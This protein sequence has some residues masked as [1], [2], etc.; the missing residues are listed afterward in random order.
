MCVLCYTPVSAFGEI[1]VIG[2]PFVAAA[3]IRIRERLGLGSPSD[4][5]Q[6]DPDRSHASDTLA[7]H[8]PAP[9]T[10]KASGRAASGASG[11]SSTPT[12]TPTAGMSIAHLRAQIVAKAPAT[13][14]MP[15]S[16]L[17]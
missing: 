14:A 10:M 4:E 3:V 8:A 13:A 7:T 9:A 6:S 17:A 1:T 16:H 11:P 15:A 5:A 2:G 12:G